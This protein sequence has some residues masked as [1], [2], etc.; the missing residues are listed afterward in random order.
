M[1]EFLGSEMR[2]STFLSA[3]ILTL[4]SLNSLLPLLFSTTFAGFIQNC[5]IKYQPTKL[6]DNTTYKLQNVH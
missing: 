2:R 4:A 6:K 1:Q 3:R 5:H